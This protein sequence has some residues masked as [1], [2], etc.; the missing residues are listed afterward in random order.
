MLASLAPLL[1]FPL[2]CVRRGD[3]LLTMSIP[4]RLTLAWWRPLA[5]FAFATGCRSPTVAWHLAAGALVLGVTFAMSP[6]GWI[7]GGRTPS[8]RRRS[9][10]VRFAPL[11]DFC[12]FASIGAARSPS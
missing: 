9:P 6:S 5:A 12:C 3:D 10:S 7:G 2:S 11:F 8:L 1:L 4:N